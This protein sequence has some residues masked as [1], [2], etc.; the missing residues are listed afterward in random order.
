VH[1]YVNYQGKDLYFIQSLHGIRALNANAYPKFF[2]YIIIIII[3]I[4][5]IYLFSILINHFQWLPLPL[6]LPHLSLQMGPTHL[7]FSFPISLKCLLRN[8]KAVTTLLGYLELSL[9]FIVMN[10]WG[11]LMGLKSALPNSYPMK[12]NKES[13][14]QNLLAGSRKTSSY[15]ARSTYSTPSIRVLP[16]IF[17]LKTSKLV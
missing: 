15:S 11:F 14:I 4:I 5:I 12:V 7:I 8:W 1:H 10:L 17:G 13:S 3:I 9:L 16:T 2:F 6:P